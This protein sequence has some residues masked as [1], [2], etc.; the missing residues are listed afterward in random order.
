MRVCVYCVCACV[1]VCVC[2][3]VR[4]SIFV[5]VYAGIE[6]LLSGFQ[7]PMSSGLVSKGSACAKPDEELQSEAGEISSK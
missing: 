1:C 7:S 6:S 2:A 3:C 4:V 5:Y